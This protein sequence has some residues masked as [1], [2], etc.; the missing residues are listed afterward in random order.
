[1]LNTPASIASFLSAFIP[2]SAAHGP[3][4]P[5]TVRAGLRR[6]LRAEA[7]VHYEDEWLLV[8]L[9]HILATSPAAPRSPAAWL[10]DELQADRERWPGLK[11]P[12]GADCE[13]ERTL[14]LRADLAGYGAL[15]SRPYSPARLHT[16]R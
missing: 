13:R 2:H 9:A 8:Q 1:M 5:D 11:Q 14:P 10:Q 15:A 7:G 16:R 4:T 6:H 3:V 12:E